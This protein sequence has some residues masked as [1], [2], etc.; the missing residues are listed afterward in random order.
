M[1]YAFQ[2]QG[3]SSIYRSAITHRKALMTGDKKMATTGSPFAVT[4]FATCR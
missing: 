4:L 2:D 3:Q 1:E